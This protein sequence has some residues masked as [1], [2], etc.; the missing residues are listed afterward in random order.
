MTSDVHKCSNQEEVD[1][2]EKQG[3]TIYDLPGG[4]RL[5]GKCLVSRAIGDF[6]LKH[7]GMSAEPTITKLTLDGTL[8]YAFVVTDGILDELSTE[9]LHKIVV[10]SDDSTEAAKRIASMAELEGE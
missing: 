3:G 8:G 6:D 1:R 9:T 10:G 2:V 7:F 4:P 5:E